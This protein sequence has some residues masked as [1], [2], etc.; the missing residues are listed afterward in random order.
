MAYSGDSLSFAVMYL[1]ALEI[2]VT[3]TWRRY[4]KKKIL[5]LAYSEIFYFFEIVRLGEESKV[6]FS[7]R[8]S[9]ESVRISY[10]IKKICDVYEKSLD[11]HFIW[12]YLNT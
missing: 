2:N 5:E 3:H 8:E 1:R 7:D 6:K 11:S 12:E 9:L 4:R 10:E